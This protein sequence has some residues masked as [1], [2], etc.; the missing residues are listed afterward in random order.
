[1]ARMNADDSR[2][3][4][5]AD[6]G[7]D[8]VLAPLFDRYNEPP[9]A[10]PLDAL[11]ARM[12]R[13]VAAAVRGASARD[14]LARR[15][16]L[17]MRTAAGWAAALAASF[18]VGIGVGRMD[19]GRA[20]VPRAAGPVASAPVSES[21]P[22]RIE[23]AQAE[24]GRVFRR[25]AARHFAASGERLAGLEPHLRA[26]RV[27]P[28]VARWSAG[29]L[30]ET[31]ILLAG[32]AGQDPRLGPLLRDLEAALAEVAALTTASGAA[33]ASLTRR[34]LDRTRVVPRLRQA[35]GGGAS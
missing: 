9:D 13:D 28:D 10:P 31:R 20:D 8:P 30:L 7:R 23:G 12:E 17:R 5:G 2:G 32:P 14:E 26:G 15:R 6:G 1:M 19:G 16:A 35:G 22:P 24:A 34:T 27:P 25:A 29:L 33:D 11:W 3:G 21:G 18:V 4:G